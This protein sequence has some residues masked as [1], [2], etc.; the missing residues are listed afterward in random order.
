M[1]S[2]KKETD[3]QIIIYALNKINKTSGISQKTIAEIIGIS[4]SQFSRLKKGEAQLKPES[5]AAKL[6]LLLINIFVS[7]NT[8]FDD[9]DKVI[10]EWLINP[11]KAFNEEAPIVIMKKITGL[12]KV[13]DYLIFYREK[14]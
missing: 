4:V 5:V 14:V 11:N 7:L 1:T 13:M 12:V 6:S 3:S 2:C 10:L 8:I 9:N